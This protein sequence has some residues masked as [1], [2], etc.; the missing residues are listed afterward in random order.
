MATPKNKSR[1]AYKRIEIVTNDQCI[2]DRVWA[3]RRARRTKYPPK[4][5]GAPRLVRTENQTTKI[6]CREPSQQQTGDG[7][8]RMELPELQR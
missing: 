7:L 1:T 5:T 6:A 8:V 3:L 4:V 2:P